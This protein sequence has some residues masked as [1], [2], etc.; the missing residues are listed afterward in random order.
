MSSSAYLFFLTPFTTITIQS[1]E[2]NMI[3]WARWARDKNTDQ[4]TNGDY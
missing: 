3:A 4:N 2:G 1:D